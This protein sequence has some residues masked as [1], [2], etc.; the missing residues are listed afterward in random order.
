MSTVDASVLGRGDARAPLRG[1]GVIW[2]EF[3]REYIGTVARYI[4]QM[5]ALSPLTSPMARPLR[6]LA[7]RARPG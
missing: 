1:C 4:E 5:Q 6:L 2:R 7:G 3:V